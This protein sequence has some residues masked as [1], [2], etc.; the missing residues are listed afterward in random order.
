MML[1]LENLD[2]L[3][4]LEI[5]P[6]LLTAFEAIKE[7]IDRRISDVFHAWCN[8]TGRHPAYGVHSW[9]WGPAMINITQDKSCMGCHSTQEHYLPTAWFTA[10]EKDRDR[11]I[12]DHVAELKAVTEAKTRKSK[13]EQLVALRQKSDRLA[14][15]LGEG[16]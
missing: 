13:A 9:S 4:D 2:D 3:D 5:T 10:S 6:E 12:A 1:D 7:Q 11:L 14:R 16:A 8:A 15:E